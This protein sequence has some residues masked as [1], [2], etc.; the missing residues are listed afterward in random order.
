MG[1]SADVKRERKAGLR[2]VKRIDHDV[3]SAIERFQRE[4][5][6]L[7]KVKLWLGVDDAQ[8]LSMLWDRFLTET[9]KMEKELAD[10]LTLVSM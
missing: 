9:R 4:V 7:L 6:R 3:D 10:F 5:K 1:T 2:S 8:R